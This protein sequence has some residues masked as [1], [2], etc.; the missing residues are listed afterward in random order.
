M[1]GSNSMELNA[2]TMKVA[3][4]YYLNNCLFRE[5]VKAVVTDVKAN[6]SNGT[7]TV[8][9]RNYIAQNSGS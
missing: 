1:E 3:V 2:A 4:Q 9:L 7:F 6:Q 8:S 5:G